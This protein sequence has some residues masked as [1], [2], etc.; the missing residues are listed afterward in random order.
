MGPETLSKEAEKIRNLL[1]VGISLTDT[2]GLA[3]TLSPRD[4]E[5]RFVSIDKFPMYIRISVLVYFNNEVITRFHQFLP[6]IFSANFSQFERLKKKTNFLLVQTQLF[7][8]VC[9][10]KK[11]S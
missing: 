3:S 4:F 6:L 7:F 5:I 2:S 8:S 10:L 9:Q 1:K 11:K